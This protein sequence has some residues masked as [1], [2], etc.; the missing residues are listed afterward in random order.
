MGWG[1]FQVGSILVCCRGHLQC[2]GDTPEQLQQGSDIKWE[3]FYVCCICFMQMI[4]NC[5]PSEQTVNW[6]DKYTLL[7]CL[8]LVVKTNFKE[9][10]TYL[11]QER[12]WCLAGIKNQESV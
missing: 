11:G 7:A 6:T 5:M 8:V 12:Q 9:I 1:R 4:L 10:Y 3:M 2:M